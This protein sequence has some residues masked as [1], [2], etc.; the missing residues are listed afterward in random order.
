LDIRDEGVPGI[1]YPRGTLVD[2]Q[3][4][5]DPTKPAGVTGGTMHP[6]YRKVKLLDIENLKLHRL[7]FEN[8]RAVIGEFTNIFHWNHADMNPQ[9]F[10]A[11]PIRG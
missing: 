4:Q 1:M 3:F 10:T 8:G 5:Y 9:S 11:P 2:P 7:R 6:M